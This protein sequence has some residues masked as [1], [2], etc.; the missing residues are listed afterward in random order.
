[1]RIVGE[2]DLATVDAL[3]AVTEPLLRQQPD[4]IAFDLSGVDF[5]DSSGVTVLLEVAQQSRSIS[6]L[7]AS[8]AARRV[9]E[10]TGLSGVF[11][12]EP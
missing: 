11:H 12:L 2:I 9:I 3:R 10:T 6:I 1:M 8:L 7:R 4:R 5:M